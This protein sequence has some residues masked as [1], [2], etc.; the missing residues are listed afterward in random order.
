MKLKKKQGKKHYLLA[1]S[2]GMLALFCIANPERVVFIK[3][4]F[5]AS[6]PYSWWI[7]LSVF[8]FNHKNKGAYVQIDKE[9]YLKEKEGSTIL[10]MI[11]CDSGDYLKVTDKKK[12]YCNG[13]YLCVAKDASSAGE[14]VDNFVFNGQI[15]SGK[16]FAMGTH[17]RS[18]DSRYFGFVDKG[19]IMAILKPIRPIFSKEGKRSE[20]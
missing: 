11:A 7:D 5:S 8:G 2:V 17:P 19:K 14:A 3:H 9:P 20:L 12:Y 6:V 16:F 10:K 4:S 18:W 1:L 15:P 13:K